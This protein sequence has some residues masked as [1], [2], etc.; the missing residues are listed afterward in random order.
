M[1]LSGF[2]VPHAIAVLEGQASRYILNARI[3]RS[4]DE[5][6]VQLLPS[7]D[8]PDGIRSASI[9]QKRANA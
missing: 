5:R 8:L 4:H 9:L 7:W 6:L 3:C 2:G 1:V